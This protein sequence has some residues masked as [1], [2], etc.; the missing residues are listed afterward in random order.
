MRVRN[1]YVDFYGA[2]NGARVLL[3][4]AGTDPLGRGLDALL[5]KMGASR[6]EVTDVFLTH[7]HGDHLASASGFRNAKVHAGAKD[8]GLVDG[9]DVPWKLRIASLIQ[10]SAR[11][12]VNNPLD[13]ILAVDVG[14]AQTVKAFPVPGHTPGSYFYLWEK[15]L[16][17]GDSIIYNEKQGEL[18]LPPDSFDYDPAQLR[19]SLGQLGKTSAGKVRAHLHGSWRLH[20]A[21]PNEEAT[22][23][24]R[25]EDARDKVMS[26]LVESFSGPP[27]LLRGL[28]AMRERGITPRGLLFLAFSPDGAVH[29]AV[30]EDPE[31]ITSIKVGEK[32]ALV[33]PQE[34]RFYHYDAIHR[35]PGD[36]VLWNGDRRLKDPGDAAEVA[37][38]VASF[39]KGGGEERAVRL[40]R[41][42]SRA[43]GW[44]KAAR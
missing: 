27:A 5:A 4:D 35:L 32:L 28:R 18:E 38:L 1:A 25:Q 34:G 6:D 9:S 2:K 36:F 8:A 22:G 16:F 10:P 7:G 40:H 3:F 44:R 11:V 13:G 33:W 41:R 26:V 31:Q 29:V 21:R 15:V 24:S 20:S 37:Q 43:A 14:A 17:V 39:L 12:K 42:T 23:R 30:P 19:Q